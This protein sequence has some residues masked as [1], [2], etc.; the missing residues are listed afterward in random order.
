MEAASKAVA[1]WLSE[2]LSLLSLPTCSFLRPRRRLVK[3]T[4]P[5]SLLLSLSLLI[6]LLLQLHKRLVEV[7]KLK[8]SLLSDAYVASLFD[9]VLFAVLFET[10][11]CWLLA[12]AY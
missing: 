4:G 11:H 8:G 7:S 1:V 3:V 2:S 9:G 10:L 5:K 6:C 12:F